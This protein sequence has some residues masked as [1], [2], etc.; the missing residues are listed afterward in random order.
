VEQAGLRV[1]NRM[2]LPP[3]RYEMRVA[4]HDQGGGNVGSVS[5]DVEVP[6]FYKLPF[7]MSGV[8]MTSLAT[9]AMVVAK[10][11]EEI[12]NLLP[13]PP[14]AARSFPQSDEIALFTEVYDN[15][16]A[17]PHKVDITTTL[18]ADDGK[19]VYKVDEERSSTEIEGKRGGYGYSVR[20]PLHDIAPGSY[21]LG[22]A[23][24][25]RLGNS[26][27]AER[28]IPIKIEGRK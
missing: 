24:R 19:V 10:N 3:G 25:S 11:D 1:F 28:Q 12:K 15:Q 14:V 8:V 2:E 4:A 26:P 6:D 7:S 13:A 27:A 23:A 16:A 21:V 20:V 18:T 9:G 22:V 17:T 5:Y